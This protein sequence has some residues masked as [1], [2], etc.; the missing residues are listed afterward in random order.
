MDNLKEILKG[1]IYIL[2]ISFVAIF[3]LFLTSESNIIK[4]DYLEFIQTN[5]P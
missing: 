1:M 4:N 3:I 5:I 2:L